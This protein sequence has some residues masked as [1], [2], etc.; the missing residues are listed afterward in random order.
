MNVRTILENARNLLPLEVRSVETKPI[1]LGPLTGT[2]DEFDEFMSHNEYELAFDAI[3]VVGFKAKASLEFWRTLAQ[4]GIVMGLF[5]EI[6]NGSYQE[7]VERYP[8]GYGNSRDETG[9]NPS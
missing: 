1:P 8:E 3:E 7:S 4:A 9:I 6:K 2:L 5:K